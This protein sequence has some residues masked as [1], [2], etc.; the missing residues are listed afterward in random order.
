[1][2]TSDQDHVTEAPATVPE[3]VA[4]ARDE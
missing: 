3:P 2:L 4:V 1:V